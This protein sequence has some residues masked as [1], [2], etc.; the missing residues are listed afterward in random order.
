ML[1][2]QH[3]HRP[4]RVE[5]GILDHTADQQVQSGVDRVRDRERTREREAEKEGEKGREGGT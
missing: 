5:H 2:R 3:R 4:L 1:Y